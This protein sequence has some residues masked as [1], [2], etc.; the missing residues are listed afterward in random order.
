MRILLQKNSVIRRNRGFTLIEMIIVIVLMAVV[1]VIGAGLIEESGRTY[2]A[3]RDVTHIGWQGRVALERM[4]AEIR[5]IA[6]TASITTWTATALTFTNTSGTSIG[7]TL[8]AGSVQRTQAPTAAPQPQPL[9]DNVSAL[10]FTYWDRTGAQVVP[11]VGSVSNIYYVTV[12]LGITKG[13]FSSNYR[14][15]VYPRNFL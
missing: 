14:T 8:A 10:G 15:T 4:E 3:G 12:T 1:S 11:G 2:S 9:A 13:D 5:A 7:Y 6:S